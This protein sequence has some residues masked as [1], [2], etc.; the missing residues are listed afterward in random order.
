MCQLGQVGCIPVRLP[1]VTERLVLRDFEP[2]DW[3]SV[4]SYASDLEVVRYMPWGPNTEEDSRSFVQSAIQRARD[5]PRRDFVLAV[6]LKAD[7]RLI[8]GCGVNV[9]NPDDRGGWIGYCLNQLFWRCGYGTEVAGA[10]IAFG[11]EQ[12]RLHRI[13]ATCDPENVG[14]VRVLEK[15]GMRREGHY[16]EH[17]WVK[18]RWCDTFVFAILDHEWNRAERPTRRNH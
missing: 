15:V 6:T 18:G 8:G 9:S 11:F 2:A 16:R 10:L 17:K 12:L 1:L 3:P 13:F 14:S 4:H 7:G 5:E